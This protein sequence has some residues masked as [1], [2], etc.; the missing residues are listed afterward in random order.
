MSASRVLRLNDKGVRQ[1][2]RHPLLTGKKSIGRGCFSA[3]FEGGKNTVLKLTAD[4][5]NYKMLNSF[6][7]VRRRHFP[8]VVADHKRVG[9]IMIAGMEY[10]IFLYEVEKLQRL[11]R[12]S[13]AGRL[14]WKLASRQRHWGL[15][16]YTNFSAS[17][18]TVGDMSRDAKLPRGVRN[19]LA[20]LERFILTCADGILDMHFGNF[21]QRSNGD[22]V[23]TDPLFDAPTLF[24][25]RNLDP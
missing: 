11:H 21:M 19:A 3:V 14:A 25:R 10:P 18:M 4:S 24:A 1:A 15:S 8:K 12:L 20:E 16:D 17:V 9:A 22:L 6:D 13:D 2:L 23:I 5:V 7:C